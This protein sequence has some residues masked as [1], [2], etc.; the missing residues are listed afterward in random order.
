LDDSFDTE[1]SV[2]LLGFGMLD[3]AQRYAFAEQFNNFMYDSPQGQ[4]RLM[5]VWSI[6]CRESENP[7]ARMIAESSA[8]YAVGKKKR[9]KANRRK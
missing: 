9:R 7:T 8:V 2:L 1:V 4:R 5:D 3:K 6:Q